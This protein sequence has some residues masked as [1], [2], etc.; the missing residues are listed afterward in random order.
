MH[1]L[2]YIQVDPVT[3]RLVVKKGEGKVPFT[4]EEVRK[5]LIEEGVTVPLHE[6]A[7]SKAFAEGKTGEYILAEGVP[8]EEGKEGYVEW[9][10]QTEEEHRYLE[11]DGKVNYLEFFR[12][13]SVANGDRIAR[14]YPPVPGK[15]GKDVRG[16]VIPAPPV[17]EARVVLG[18][19]VRLNEEER[20]IY[21]TT[22]GL[23][24]VKKKA[25]GFHISVIPTLI[26]P[27]DVDLST[28]NLRF[29][30]DIQISGNITE[31]M[32]VEADGDVKV[33]GNVTRATV[34]AGGSIIVQGQ[35]IS[36]FLTAGISPFQELMRKFQY[37]TGELEKVALG[38]NQLSQM[39][40]GRWIVQEEKNILPAIRLISKQISPD[41][42]KVIKEL[43]MMRQKITLAKDLSDAID[44][45]CQ[46]K[47]I[48]SDKSAI[49]ITYPKFLQF[50]STFK[51]LLIAHPVE[52][53]REVMVVI[54][55]LLNSTIQSEGDVVITQ[56]G[57]YHSTIRAKGNVQGM[58]V[59][60]GGEIEANE[61]I[62][63]E[64][65]GSQA[66]I[67]T[68]LKVRLPEGIIRLTKAY[69]ETEVHIDDLGY[70]FRTEEVKI[71][72]YIQDR[73]IHI[74]RG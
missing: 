2:W 50:I 66:G 54:S 21:A 52:E 42:E 41:L 60:R 18:A 23:L 48:T 68:I 58:G 9:Y 59:V 44:V 57:S 63:L 45:M 4:E 37:V 8:P 64:E 28:G 39:P 16:K 35:V 3:V 19:G 6:E 36:S 1:P 14:I 47:E 56:R 27:G 10:V 69:P 34:R 74:S 31:Q 15:E 49:E 72:I 51:N 65:V 33:S 13:P 55:G 32:T 12:I 20:I 17:K 46:I 7:L 71:S 29:R 24:K 30:G 38:L 5:R 73:E 11:E 40:Q 70:I 25:G 22:N 62:E 67:K 53:K 43:G 26:Q 61:R